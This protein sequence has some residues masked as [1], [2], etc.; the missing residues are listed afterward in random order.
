M[1]RLSLLLFLVLSPTCWSEPYNQLNIYLDADQTHMRASGQA[2]QLGIE[3]ALSEVDFQIHD[4]PISILVKDHRGN[5]ARSKAHLKQFLKDDRAIANVTGL[6]SPPLLAHMNFINENSI[7]TLNPWAAAAP[8][9]RSTSNENWIFRLSVDDSKA[10][11]FITKVAIDE[12]GYRSPFLILEETGWG[13]SNLKNMSKSLSER[14]IKAVGSQWFQWQISD[15]AARIMIRQAIN[16]NADVIFLVANAP[17]GLAIARAM[18][19]FPKEDRIAIRSHWGITGGNFQH[20]LGSENL[21]KLDLKFIQTRFNFFDTPS[22][23]SKL[24]INKLIQSQRISSPKDISAV[25]GFSHAYDLTKLFLTACEQI[26]FTGDIATDRRAIKQALES[27]DKK[28]TGL[29]K[30][31]QSPFSSNWKQNPDAHEALGIRDMAM[32]Y[33]APDGTIRLKQ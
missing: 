31:Y 29:L 32:G 3:T 7:L 8:I 28:V 4:V 2:I 33:F 18:L 23:K 27:L 26:K 15:N 20:Q 14:N 24:L 1:N 12:E 30:S 21:K 10:G 9:T 19:S 13:K 16:A 17:E 5:S 6:H 22:S 25:T 11:E